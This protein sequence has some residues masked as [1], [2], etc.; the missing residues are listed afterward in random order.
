MILVQVA[1]LPRVIHSKPDLFAKVV[2]YLS[3][4]LEN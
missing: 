4:E 3:E 2:T 1:C